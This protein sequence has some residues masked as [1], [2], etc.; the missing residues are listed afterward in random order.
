M[1]MSMAAVMVLMPRMAKSLMEGLMPVSES[2]R[3]WLNK[4]AL[5]NV[6]VYWLDIAVIRSSSGYFDSINFLVPIITVLLAVILPGNQVLPFGDLATIPFVVAFIVGAARGNIIHSGH[7]GYWIWLQLVYE[8][9]TDGALIFTD[10]RK[11]K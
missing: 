11:A 4:I 1:R 7:C 9:A 2:A 6:N 3:T 5:A 10:I 8:A